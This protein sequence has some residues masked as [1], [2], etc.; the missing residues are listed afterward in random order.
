MARAA[1]AARE[2]RD[3]FFMRIGASKAWAGTAQMRVTGLAVMGRN[4]A[5][6]LAR[7]GFVV[8]VHKDI[9]YADMQL[10]AEAVDLLRQG[11]A[12]TR[13]RSGRSSRHGTPG[14]W[15]R[16]LPLPRRQLMATDCRRP[17]SLSIIDAHG[18]PEDRAA[19]NH[20][21][22]LSSTGSILSTSAQS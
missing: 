10:I 22:T 3:P 21:S 14:T 11:V 5:R 1:R 19:V 17:G 7:H 8:G 18:L 9:E 16:L 12:V 13:G 15:S 2:P 6:N 20:R 4:L